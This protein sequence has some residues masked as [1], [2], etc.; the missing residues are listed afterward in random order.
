[1]VF[2]PLTLGERLN[3]FYRLNFFLRTMPALFFKMFFL[4]LNHL[5]LRCL[6]LCAQCINGFVF[7]VYVDALFNH[8]FQSRN[9]VRALSIHMVLLLN[10]VGATST[11]M[12][13]PCKHA[14]A[15]AAHVFLPR[16]H[17]SASLNRVFLPRNHVR[18]PRNYTLN[19]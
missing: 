19:P 10:H 12:F 3:D 16:N 17:V 13:L 11:H 7:S 2:L 15:S 5:P 14:S 1:M 9:H 6:S 4:N 8:V 18:A